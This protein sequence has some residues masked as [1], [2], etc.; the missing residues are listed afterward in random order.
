MIATKIFLLGVI[1]IVFAAV[2]GQLA[3]KDIPDNAKTFIGGL[4]FLGLV[5]MAIGGMTWTIML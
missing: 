3:G 4:V 2:L 5:V 1:I